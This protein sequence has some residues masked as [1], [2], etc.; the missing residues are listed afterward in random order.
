MECQQQLI[1][2]RQ[3]GAAGAVDMTGPHYYT[4]EEPRCDQEGREGAA[5]PSTHQHLHSSSEHGQELLPWPPP[6]KPPPAPGPSRKLGR[7]LVV[8]QTVVT[9]TTLPATCTGN[10]TT[11]SVNVGR[12]SSSSSVQQ[13]Q[14]Q[15]QMLIV[16]E[17]HE[18]VPSRSGG[19]MV[20]TGTHAT[21][22]CVCVHMLRMHACVRT[23]TQR[24]KSCRVGFIVTYH[25]LITPV[26][27]PRVP[28]TY[29][30]HSGD[31]AHGPVPA[32]R[33]H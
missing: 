32:C 28:H 5:P 4:V 18:H 22:V 16:R 10:S 27:P 31:E 6:V 15:Q 21:G 13:Q 9:R 8:S 14:Q 3:A 1:L 30:H 25:Q 26:L 20:P 17:L 23:Y 11:P 33:R 2:N 19:R 7:Q 29:T 12:N 24:L